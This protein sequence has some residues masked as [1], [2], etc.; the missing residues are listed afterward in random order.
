[1]LW[2]IVSLAT[3]VGNAGVGEVSI[4]RVEWLS[5]SDKVIFKHMLKKWD[6]GIYENTYKSNGN[7]R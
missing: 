7:S 6:R 2:K 4:Y 5:F 3:G 1:M